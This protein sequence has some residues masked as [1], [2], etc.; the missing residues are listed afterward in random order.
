MRSVAFG[1][2]KTALC[3]RSSED[4][5]FERERSAD[6]TMWDVL[7]E[8]RLEE[9]LCDVVLRVD[10]VEFNVHKTILCANSPYFRSLFIRWSSSEQ[11]VYTITNVSPDIM[12][13]II[14]YI[15]TQE[16]RVTTDN[17][18]AL[19]VMADYLLMRDL[20]RNCYDFLKAHLS[21][22]NCLGIWQY[23]DTYSFRKL[24]DRAYTYALRHF[25]DVVRSPS[26]EFLELNEEQ[27]SGILERD[28]LNVKQ[29]KTAFE[30]LIMWIE[31]KPDIRIQHIANLLL[32]VRL[33]LIDLE[34]F[35]ENIKT[36]PL[37]SS[38]WECRPIIIRTMK[39]MFYINKVGHNTRYPDPLARPRLPYSILFAVGGLNDRSATNTVE[40]YNSRMDSWKCITSREERVRAYHGTV[41]LDGFVY[42]IGGFDGT[43]Y[44]NSV[45]KFNPLDRTWNEVSPMNYCRCYVSVAILDGYIYAMGG[46]EGREWLNTAERYQPST[47]QWSL[48]P[49]MH[50]IRSD[51]SATTLL[52]KI[53]ICGGFNGDMCLFTAECFDPRYD[54]WTQ[55]ERMH[56]QR[57]GVGVIALNNEVSAIGG[58]DGAQRLRCVEAYNPRTNSWRMLASMFN[59]RSNFGVEVMDGRLYVV[60]G[61]IGE[62]TTSNCEYYD[63]ESN[64]CALSCCVISG[65]PNITDYTIAYDDFL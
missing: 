42:V 23:A 26:S 58:F 53:Y 52:G 37:V 6:M 38:S 50:E 25:E 45:S 64:D 41:F 19:L 17:V 22:E 39:A 65:L 60:G 8:M 63:E 9:E 51:A 14:H 11:T 33:A 49:S 56:V 27:L 28:E 46:F 57:S 2:H 13:I 47:N 12:A 30:A 4:M 3:E 61:N 15:Y 62:D 44:F 20:V 7:N 16:I 24:Q 29:E 34:Y 18:Q 5:S 21:P 59:P 43:E 10:E 32:K 40:T 35:L 54:Q 36:H 31:H 55:I 48:I 1:L